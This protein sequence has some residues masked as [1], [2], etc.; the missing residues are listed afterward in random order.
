MA[1]LSPSLLAQEQSILKI[2]FAA[3]VTALLFYGVQVFMVIHGLYLYFESPIATRARRRLYMVLSVIICL[4]NS[5]GMITEMVEMQYVFTELRAPGASLHYMEAAALWWQVLGSVCIILAH[6]CADGLLLYRCFIVWQGSWAAIALPLLLFAAFGG[7]GIG[8]VIYSTRDYHNIGLVS[9][10]Y[11]LS[12]ALNAGVTGLIIWKL[13]RSRTKVTRLLNVPD[14][15]MY[16]GVIGLLVESALP[17]SIVALVAAPISVYFGTL[18]AIFA[19]FCPQLI[20]YRV[21]HGK[22]FMSAGYGTESTSLG[23]LNFYHMSSRRSIHIDL[24]TSTSCSS[25]VPKR[26][27]TIG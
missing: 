15:T 22:S 5:Y 27:A 4:L 24:E 26:T 16:T 10:L 1:T 8:F 13:L 14:E 6:L 12:A 9:A 21:A 3:F 19:S 25:E 2:T 20:I 17:F 23:T 18:W 11:T 7:T